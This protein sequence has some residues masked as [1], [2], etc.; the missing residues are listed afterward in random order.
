[1]YYALVGGSHKILGSLLYEYEE[2]QGVRLLILCK[3]LYIVLKITLI[4]GQEVYF[5]LF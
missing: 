1:M 3:A 5:D 4:L 2:I